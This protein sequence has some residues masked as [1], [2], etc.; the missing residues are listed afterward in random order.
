MVDGLPKSPVR[1]DQESCKSRRSVAGRGARSTMMARVVS[2]EDPTSVWNEVAGLYGEGDSP[3][4][5]FSRELVRVAAL[6]PGD[7]VDRSRHRERARAR[8]G[9]ARGRAGRRGRRRFRRGHARCGREASGPSRRRERAARVYGRRAPGYRGCDLRRRDRVLGV[10]V[11]RLLERRPRGM[12]TGPPPG[13][14]SRLLGAG[15]R[16]RSGDEPDR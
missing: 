14:A 9:G 5:Y 3:Y 4:G 15:D 7:R 1:I 10:P 11:R 8:A 13:R 12:A 2:G 6:S 16:V